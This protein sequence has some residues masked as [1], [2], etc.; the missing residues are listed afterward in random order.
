[1]TT[2][3]IDVRGDEIF[4]NDVVKS[5]LKMLFDEFKANF[6]N[7]AD[8]QGTMNTRI[9]SMTYKSWNTAVNNGD[10]IKDGV[11]Q[12]SLTSFGLF[13]NNGE[14]VF[15]LDDLKTHI[16]DVK[17]NSKEKNLI[18]FLRF[19]RNKPSV[20]SAI[21]E[22]HISGNYKIA[23]DAGTSVQQFFINTPQIFESFGKYIDPSP[24]RNSNIQFPTQTNRIS[25][26]DNAFKAIGYNS[27]YLGQQYVTKLAATTK[28]HD[29]YDYD[30]TIY[31]TQITNNNNTRENDTSISTYFSGNEQKKQKLKQ[32]SG[33]STKDKVAI[34][35]GKG[36]GDK[37]QSFIAHINKLINPV[38]SVAVATNDDV[39]FLFC[40]FLQMSCL[41]TSTGYEMIN[42]VK[43]VKLD[44]IMYYEPNKIDSAG[45]LEKLVSDFDAKKTEIISGYDRF[46]DLIRII[47]VDRIPLIV[48]AQPGKSFLYRPEFYV[49]IIDDLELLKQKI[50][51][52]SIPTAAT[53]DIKIKLVIDKIKELQNYTVN[54]FI[55]EMKTSEYVL[56][57][58]AT[59]YTSNRD[60]A[61]KQSLFNFMHNNNGFNKNLNNSTFY[62]IGNKYF[63]QMSMT[64]TTNRR[65]RSGG[66]SAKRR[67][68]SRKNVAFTFLTHETQLTPDTKTI[69]TYYINFMKGKTDKNFVIEVSEDDID[70]VEKS[71]DVENNSQESLTEMTTSQNN[72]SPE[73]S[74]KTIQ[75]R[76]DEMDI[77]VNIDKANK[78]RNRSP[79][80]PPPKIEKFDPYKNLYL[81]LKDL[82]VEYSGSGYIVRKVNRQRKIVH[83]DFFSYW[84]E[85]MLRFEIEGDYSTETLKIHTQNIFNEFENIELLTSTRTKGTQKIPR[86]ALHTTSSANKIR[87]HGMT[88]RHHGIPRMNWLH[89]MSMGGNTT[90]K[91][92][93]NITRRA[94]D[95]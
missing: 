44:K 77:A 81:Q 60:G 43:D 84:N 6:C 32:G 37:L 41:V 40:I 2:I 80:P 23:F 63:R 50:Q 8:G 25:I 16:K 22:D 42:G 58:S 9:Q 87:N 47:N 55:K 39:V 65:M 62:D 61:I 85:M 93:K 53:T 68:M 15:S 48:L 7:P 83:K 17:K 36:L 27:N 5:D 34:I 70:D 31:G 30:M 52:L 49:A 73:S 71:I 92:K 12:A 35:I 67:K 89:A 75:T 11:N 91:N 51:A 59:K 66:N 14:M 19:V 3:N 21:T 82:F 57:P 24:S 88:E 1:M 95:V 78:K 79:T 33:L 4:I 18:K 64:N 86:Y 74:A 28:G 29:K 45:F 20:N 56:S 26:T 38:P 90:R 54:I 72:D 94:V 46:I 69:D 76:G 13:N 10:T